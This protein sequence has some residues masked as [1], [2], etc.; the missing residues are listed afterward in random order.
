MIEEWDGDGAILIPDEALQ[1]L[2]LDVSDQLP[3]LSHQTSCN[4]KLLCHPARFFETEHECSV[5]DAHA[6]KIKVIIQSDRE[7]VINCFPMVQFWLPK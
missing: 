7:L 1:E 6:W 3:G 4:P 5:V 2:E